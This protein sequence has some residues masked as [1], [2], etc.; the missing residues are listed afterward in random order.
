MRKL[1]FKKTGKAEAGSAEEQIKTLESGIV[2][3]FL[4]GDTGSLESYYAD[5]AVIIRRTARWR[6]KP[7]TSRL[8][9]PVLSNSTP[10]SIAKR[11]YVFTGTWR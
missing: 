5:D 7:K 8:S 9:S 6:P 2:R 10:L 4:K 11:R 1:A 3:A